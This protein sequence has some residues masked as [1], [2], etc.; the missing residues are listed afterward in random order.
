[1][2]A[3]RE[4]YERAVVVLGYAYLPKV[5]SALRKRWVRL[6]NPRA[7]IRFGHD[8]YLGPGFSIHAPKGG[9][10]LCG[11]HSSFR[12]RFRADLAGPDARIAIGVGC[13]FTYDVYFDCTHSITVGDRVGLAQA[14]CLDDSAGPLTLADDVQVHS[15]V[16][17]TADVAPRI[18]FQR[19]R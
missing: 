14:N 2:R 8:T 1:M 13:Y 11:E 18:S 12:R 5:A 3:L 19:E 16:T 15:K 9:S 10:F 17:I 4:R 7:E 6:R